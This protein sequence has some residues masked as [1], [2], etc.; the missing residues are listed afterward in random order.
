M[1][2]LQSPLPAV[3][4]EQ[5]SLVTVKLCRT[6]SQH[7]KTT[8]QSEI[9]PAPMSEGGGRHVSGSAA[10]ELW[11]RLELSS[12]PGLSITNMSSDWRTG[13]A[14]CALVNRFRP[15]VLDMRLV[16][17]AEDTEAWRR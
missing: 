16:S 14:F 8:H 2:V 4:S 7:I 12:Y 11:C 3:Q 9:T 6:S 17:R 15:E 5:D 13:V 10:L 1:L